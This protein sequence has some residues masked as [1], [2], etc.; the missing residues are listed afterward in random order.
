MGENFFEEDFLNTLIF[1]QKI[2]E[3]FWERLNFTRPPDWFKEEYSTFC[4][5]ERFF[6][7]TVKLKFEDLLPRFNTF[8]VCF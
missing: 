6:F 3:Y 8:C 1:N 7:N 2:S 4:L 5:L